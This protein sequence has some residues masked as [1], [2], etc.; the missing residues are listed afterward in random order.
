MHLP[1]QILFKE[2]HD[3][4]RNYWKYDLQLSRIYWKDIAR[5]LAGRRVS[6]CINREANKT[7]FSN[8]RVKDVSKC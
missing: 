5:W 1:T 3:T 7:G 8:A 6:Q 2:T 4:I